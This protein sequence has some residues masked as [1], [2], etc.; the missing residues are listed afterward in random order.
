METLA[1]LRA[2]SWLAAPQRRRPDGETFGGEVSWRHLPGRHCVSARCCAY[3]ETDFWIDVLKCC[4]PM[5]T[6]RCRNNAADLG[7][8]RRQLRGYVIAIRR[9]CGGVMFAIPGGRRD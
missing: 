2:E 8:S 7:T 5:G 9:Q 1:R 6:H 3:G 4:P